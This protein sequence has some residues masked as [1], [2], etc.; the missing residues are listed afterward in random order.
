[1]CTVSWLVE[2]DGYQL[3]CNRDEKRTRP[4]AHGPAV[5]RQNGVRVISPTDAAAGG[6]WIGVNEWGTS[7][8]LL[9]RA[10]GAYG[11]VSRGLLV[12][13]LAASGDDAQ[14]AAALN[15]RDLTPYAAFT[16]LVLSPSR[17]ATAFEWDGRRLIA[18]AGAPSPLL[19]SSFHPQLVS[20]RRRSEFERCAARAGG[21]NAE[22]LRTFH[23]SHAG[24]P[25]AYSPCMHRPDAETVS[26]S[27]VEVRPR[28]IRFSYR[29]GPLCRPGMIETVEI[30]LAPKG[31][32]A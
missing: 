7:L 17:P 1:M 12:A 27:V 19:S 5:R 13:D 11:Q 20:E 16:L 24:G 29:A 26:L 10:P 30:S 23:A 6:T 14:V 21:V 22:A 25:S 8:C 2:P 32:C 3:F 4:P 31:L 28:L 9:N 18:R 15:R